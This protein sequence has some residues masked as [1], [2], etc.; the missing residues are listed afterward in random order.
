MFSPTHATP[1]GNHCMLQQGWTIFKV[2]FLAATHS[3]TGSTIS[4][5]PR[6]PLA[7]SICPFL[8]TD[9][10]LGFSWVMGTR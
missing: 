3:L 4:L 7:H 2:I 5:S 1:W 8:T 6:V 9:K 10:Y